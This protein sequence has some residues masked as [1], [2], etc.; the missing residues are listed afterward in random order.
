MYI[1]MCVGHYKCEEEDTISKIKRLAAMGFKYLNAVSLPGDAPESEFKELKAVVEDLGVVPVMCDSGVPLWGEFDPAKGDEILE[2]AKPYFD[3]VAEL[4]NTLTC[5]LPPKWNE[6][7][8][9]EV[10]WG[11]SIEWTRKYA[12]LLAERGMS[13]ACEVEPERDFI[14]FKFGDAVRWIEHVD[15]DNFF[16]NVDTG[17]FTLW[18]YKAKW[19][20]KYTDMVVHAHITDNGGQHQSWALGTGITDNVGYVN[21]LLEGGFDAN[22]KKFGI[23]PVGC[24]EL[25]IPG[26]DKPNFDE[27]L[28][29]S[30][31]WLAENLPQLTLC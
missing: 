2:K 13:A 19:L 18:K 7:L 23:P 21:A 20:K 17:H 4:G 29:I 3:R 24:I 6:E 31:E 16:L 28:K 10:S 5:P 22:A 12:A 30:L 1:G 25:Y 14:T 11:T 15:C 8:P 26:H 9:L 27:E